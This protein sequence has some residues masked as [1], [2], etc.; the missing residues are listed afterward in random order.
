MVRNRLFNVLLLCLLFSGEAITQQDAS[1]N[2]VILY[3]NDLHNRLNG[4][5]PGIRY[6]P[7]C[8]NQ[9]EARG[10]FARIASLIQDE[11]EINGDNVLVLD[12]GDFLIGT[13]FSMLEESSG[14]QLSLMKRMG[15]DV[16]TLGNHEFDFGPQALAHI[17]GKSAE[18]GFVPSLVASN[19]VFSKEDT[20]D[21]GLEKL[22]DQQVLRPYQ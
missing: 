4:F 15:Y 16:V 21:D 14:F 11:R 8:S 22:F 5:S 3:T 19:L 18:N 13:F 10:G 9:D 7:P 17:I 20:A 2:L 12:A 1:Q 6:P